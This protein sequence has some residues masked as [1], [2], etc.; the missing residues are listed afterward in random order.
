M[1]GSLFFVMSLYRYND[2]S[3]F[4]NLVIPLFRYFDILIFR[5]F[6][7]SKVKEHLIV[8]MFGR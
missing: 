4:R 3:L 5:Y 8:K 6:G 7:N 2:I 1:L